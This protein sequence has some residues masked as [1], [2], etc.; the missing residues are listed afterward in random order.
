VSPCSEVGFTLDNL[1][2]RRGH[3]RFSAHNAEI[4]AC[5]GLDLCKAGASTR[6][7]TSST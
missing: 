3:F 4:R 1:P 2:I 5:P 7:L 6:P